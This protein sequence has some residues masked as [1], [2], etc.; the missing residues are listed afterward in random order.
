MPLLLHIWQRHQEMQ[1][2]QPKMTTVGAITKSCLFYIKDKN[3]GY[4]FLADIGAET[5]VIIP[6]LGDKLTNSTFQPQA[7]NGS[8]LPK[9]VNRNLQGMFQ[10]F[11]WT[12]LLAN[13]RKPIPGAD[14]IVH[15]NLCV[16]VNSQTLSGNMIL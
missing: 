10:D 15:F 1:L 3:S 13:V 14:F 7:E 2:Q 11:T 8:C 9:M 5:S 6:P 12:F 16:Q 4:T